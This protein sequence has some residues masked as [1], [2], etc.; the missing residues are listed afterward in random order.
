MLDPT[1][2]A[3][4]PRSRQR[5]SRQRRKQGRVLLKVEVDEFALVAALLRSGRLCETR[6]VPAG[7]SRDGGGAP[8]GG[9]DR[10]MAV[11]RGLTEGGATFG[12][13]PGVL[14]AHAC[15]R[16]SLGD[17]ARRAELAEM[18]TDRKLKRKALARLE[19][20]RLEMA[21]GVRTVVGG[22]L[23][24]SDSERFRSAPRTG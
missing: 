16:Q 23:L 20:A 8:F 2:R 17:L 3:R 22:R 6:P 14:S 11:T 13:R 10:A 21:G 7:K 15:A 18:G 24:A 4:Q 19:A 5:R 1:S 9:L 12:R